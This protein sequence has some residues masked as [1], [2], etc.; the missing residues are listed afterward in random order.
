MRANYLKESSMVFNPQVTRQA[1]MPF[2]I[3]QAVPIEGAVA[4]YCH[5]YHLNFEQD[6]PKIKHSCGYFDVVGY[7]VAAHSYIVPQ[8]KGTLWV[9]HG[10]LEHSGLYRHIIPVLLAANFCVIIY[11]L[12]AHGLSSG[13]RASINTFSEYQA[14]L[15]HLIDYF[16]PHL[17]APWLGIGQSTG[18]AILMDY[19]LS[20]CAQQ[21]APIF[22]RLLL[23]APLVY[24]AKMQWL[25]MKFA[26]WWF[27]SVRTGLPRVFRHNTSNADFV[28]FMRDE[29]PLQARWI[30]VSWLLALKEWVEYIH[31]LP[32]C[33]LPVWIVQGGKDKTVNGV[34]NVD[35][36]GTK[37]SVQHTLW[38]AEASHQLANEREDL[39]EPIIDCLQDFL[40]KC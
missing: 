15:Q 2:D 1:L 16:R 31:R 25:Q 30:P 22:E 40:S 38:L 8:A 23:L 32:A 19:V 18:G 34:Y 24:P 39:R 27:K 28:R 6:F 5:F 17:P 11:D 7:R 14:V 20:Q 10:Y 37:F 29:D 13:T 33:D 26:F 12:P 9:L 36:I 21:Q 3:K 35:F 4:D